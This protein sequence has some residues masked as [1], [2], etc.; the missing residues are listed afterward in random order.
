M[1][2]RWTNVL[3]CGCWLGLAEGDAVEERTVTQT[4]GL[5]KNQGRWRREDGVLVI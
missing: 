2:T 4:L 5:P 1:T 3:D